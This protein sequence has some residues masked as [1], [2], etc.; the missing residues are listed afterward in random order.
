MVSGIFGLGVLVLVRI[1]RAQRETRRRPPDAMAAARSWVH[2]RRSL[3]G[4][5]AR[6]TGGYAVAMASRSLSV[7]VCEARSTSL[8]AHE[9]SLRALPRMRCELRRAWG[10]DCRDSAL[11]GVYLL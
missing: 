11:P 1:W 10:Q 6:T 8:C 7:A 3:D 4:R 5:A 2:T 9:R